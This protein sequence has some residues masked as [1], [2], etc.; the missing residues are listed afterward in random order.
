MF[1]L[2]LILLFSA[3]ITPQ[4]KEEVEA[5]ETKIDLEVKNLKALI[6]LIPENFRDEEFSVPKKRLEEAGVSVTVAGLQS[7]E[8]RGMLG[9]KTKPDILLDDVDIDD[10]DV[11]I[12]PGGQGSV[13]Y[14]WN[15][16][17]VLSLVKEAYEK[18]KIVASICLSGAVL[19]NA[20][21]L[22]GKKA[23]V[24]PTSESVRILKDKGANYIDQG[25]VVDGKIVTAKG[26]T[27]AERF[28]GE[29]LRLLS[30]S[31]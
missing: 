30:E 11:L 19:A 25:V 7:G 18:D 4:E 10:Y 9:M 17:R 8:A 6:I 31:E 20:G 15:N 21:I 22:E 24:F 26:P 28:A 13:K 16:E 3:C 23:T 1:F 14:L 27:D 5:E 29:I 12:V 2:I